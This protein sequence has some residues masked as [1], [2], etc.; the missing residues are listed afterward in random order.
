MAQLYLIADD[1]EIARRRSRVPGRVIEA[2][3]DLA[4]AGHYWMAETSKTALDAAGEPIRPKLVI[5]ARRVPIYY[6][7]RVID[8][9]SLP[10]EGSLQARVLSE[11]GIAVACV[12][13]DAAGRRTSHTPR[14]PDD[15]TFFLRRVGG[16]SAHLW[17]LFRT[18]AEALAWLPQEF[19]GDAEAVAW[20]NALAVQTYDELIGRHAGPA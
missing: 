8:L 10:E 13:V 11:H 6:G 19:P 12:T 20:A 3:P 7:P 18:K 1:G 15:P 9:D 5:D 4:Q 17:R 16:A 2:W 14:S